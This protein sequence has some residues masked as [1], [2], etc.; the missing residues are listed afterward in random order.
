MS[1]DRCADVTRTVSRALA[2]GAPDVRDYLP[3][4]RALHMGS[5]ANTA[6]LAFR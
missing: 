6:K 2:R 3:E 5:N 4:G 1:Q